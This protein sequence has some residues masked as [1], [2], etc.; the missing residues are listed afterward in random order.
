MIAHGGSRDYF[1][2]S[3]TLDFMNAATLGLPNR[4]SIS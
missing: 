4:L 3:M 2:P 1:D